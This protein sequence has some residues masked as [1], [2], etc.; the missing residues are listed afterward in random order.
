MYKNRIP[1]ICNCIYDLQLDWRAKCLENISIVLE[2]I[3]INFRTTSPSSI[4]SHRT[5]WT[6]PCIMLTESLQHPSWMSFG[7]LTVALASPHFCPTN[8]FWAWTFARRW[9]QSMCGF[10]LWRSAKNVLV[11]T[12]M[13]PSCGLIPWSTTS[14]ITA[15]RQ[16]WT[17]PFSAF[18]ILK[19][20]NGKIGE[21]ASSP[22]T[23]SLNSLSFERRSEVNCIVLL[24][25]LFCIGTAQV[26]YCQM[27]CSSDLG[28]HC[29]W[30]RPVHWDH[31]DSR[32]RVTQEGG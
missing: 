9:Q 5:P 26:A 23:Y 18:Q 30:R 1:F 21:D 16:V 13:L 19:S 3:A 2:P 15:N 31:A 10:G 7:G 12:R 14:R 32:G 6:G 28:A 4:H 25:M 8:T 17:R 24:L 22:N 11:S 27:Q 29:S 20:S